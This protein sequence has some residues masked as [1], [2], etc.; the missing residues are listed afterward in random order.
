MH[1]MSVQHALSFITLVRRDAALRDELRAQGIHATLDNC[2]TS[3]AR[4]NL[5]FSI[6]ELE[7]AFRHEW[8]MRSIHMGVHGAPEV[9]PPL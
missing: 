1:L 8:M 3:G 4:R 7:T 6:S 9:V 2:V 5:I